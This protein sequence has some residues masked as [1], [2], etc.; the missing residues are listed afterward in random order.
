MELRQLRYFLSVINYGS[1]SRAAEHA[2]VTQQAISRNIRALEDSVGVQ[3]VER[4]HRVATP[5]AYGNILISYAKNILIESD[6]FQRKIDN[7]LASTTSRVRLGS[8]PTAAVQL[9]SEAVLS[10]NRDRGDIHI[11]VIASA[12]PSA[13]HSLMSDEMDL[14]IG[15]DNSEVAY[16]GLE[17]EVI[18]TELYCVVA[19]NQNPLARAKIVSADDLSQSDWVLGRYLGEVEMGWRN[20]FL[21]RSL[22]VP[23]AKITTTSLE[24][25]KTVLVSSPFLSLLPLQL[26]E[27]EV[28]Y[29]ALCSLKVEGFFWERPVAL[30]Y[31]RNATINDAT[32]ALIEALRKSAKK[33]RKI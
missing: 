23:E 13:E 31:R 22:S 17:R 20:A 9:V 26:I 33:Y 4:D 12:L 3:L 25:C 7:A 14:F 19:G 8:G 32:A 29:N 5:T 10:L 11:D 2:G 28:E 18:A 16:E 27:A 15:L 30:F 21:T 6:E 1:F 24:F